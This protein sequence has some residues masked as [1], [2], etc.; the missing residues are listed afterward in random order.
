MAKV[1]VT[2][3]G[4][5][6]RTRRTYSTTDP[7]DH[8]PLIAQLRAWA[9]AGDPFL[10][11]LDRIEGICKSIL[12]AASIAHDAEAL[13]A[14]PRKREEDTR[15]GYSLRA[16]MRLQ[17]LRQMLERGD[18][19]LAADLALDLGMLMAEAGLK[20]LADQAFKSAIG[21][22]KVSRNKTGKNHDRNAAIH[23]HFVAEMAKGRLRHRVITEIAKERDLEYDTVR[24]ILDRAIRK[25]GIPARRARVLD[26]R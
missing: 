14:G 3:T 13:L 19:K 11:K 18:V 2:G 16:L 22:T 9:D 6:R 23:R 15:E 4:S 1:T 17:L 10:A 20:P 24:K 21:R 5:T 26:S 7:M 8:A 12:D 25:S